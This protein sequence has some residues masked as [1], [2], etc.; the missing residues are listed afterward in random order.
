MDLTT[1]DSQAFLSCSE[2]S[3]YPGDG[4]GCANGL[5]GTMT[6][7]KANMWASDHGG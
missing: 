1:K 4:W 2:S 3:S 6:D 5:S 7:D